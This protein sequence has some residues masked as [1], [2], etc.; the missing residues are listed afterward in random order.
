MVLNWLASLSP[1]ASSSIRE[2]YGGSPLRLRK[3]VSARRL[4]K[5]PGLAESCGWELVPS[6]SR[7]CPWQIS[8]IFRR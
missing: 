2:R 3:T 1:S 8:K 7:R 4:R 6:G 5:E